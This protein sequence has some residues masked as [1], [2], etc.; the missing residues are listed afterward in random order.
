MITL[1]K[2][3]HLKSLSGI[4]YKDAFSDR[5]RANYE[6]LT[7]VMPKE[8]L[9]H[10]LLEEPEHQEQTNHIAMIVENIAVLNQNS[11]MIELINQMLN[12]I[13]MI[14]ET[15]ITYQDNVYIGCILRKMG[16]S[17]VS[18]FLQRI[19]S[20]KEEYILKNQLLKKY[21]QENESLSIYELAEHEKP[22]NQT[23]TGIIQNLEKKKENFL[24]EHIIQRLRTVEIYQTVSRWNYTQGA[25]R[26]ILFHNELALSEQQENILNIRLVQEKRKQIYPHCQMNFISSN[27]YEAELLQNIPDRKENITVENKISVTRENVF[28]CLLKAAV[29]SLAKNISLAAVFRQFYGKQQTDWY[30]IGFEICNTAKNTVNRC[31]WQYQKEQAINTDDIQ[32]FLEQQNHLYHYELSILERFAANMENRKKLLIYKKEE[33]ELESNWEQTAWNKNV[34]EQ[35]NSEQNSFYEDRE[36]KIGLENKEISFKLKE[37]LNEKNTKVIQNTEKWKEK[38]ETRKIN[39]KWKKEVW[40]KENENS[41]E[42]WYKENKKLFFDLYCEMQ[43]IEMAENYLGKYFG[44]SGKKAEE[45]GEESSDVFEE[46]LIWM[47][48]WIEEL[49]LKRKKNREQLYEDNQKQTVEY[50]FEGQFKEKNRENKW[51]NS[52]IKNDFSENNSMFSQTI[53]TTENKSRKENQKNENSKVSIEEKPKEKIAEKEQMQREKMQIEKSTKEDIKREEVK[54]KNRKEE[55][56]NKKTEKE[57]IQ[58]EKLQIEKEKIQKEKS[59]KEKLQIENFE[60]EEIQK[61]RATEEIREIFHQFITQKRAPYEQK[62][63]FNISDQPEFFFDTESG[64]AEQLSISKSQNLYENQT[65]IIE[66]QKNTDQPNSVLQKESS[67]EDKIF[68]KSRKEV[69]QVFHKLNLQT[70]QTDNKKQTASIP[71]LKHPSSFIKTQSE[72]VVNELALKSQNRY[73]G[74]EILTDI[75][76]P[77]IMNQDNT[78]IYKNIDTYNNTNIYNNTDTYNNTGT[79]NNTDTYNSVDTY[80]KSQIKKDTLEQIIE[81]GKERL[82]ENIYQQVIKPTETISAK[83]SASKHM[84]IMETEKDIQK[85]VQKEVEKYAE[86]EVIQQIFYEIET[87]NLHEIQKSTEN[88][89]NN[90][91]YLQKTKAAEIVYHQM[92]HDM[93]KPADVSQTINKDTTKTIAVTEKIL[94]QNQI[95]LSGLPAINQNQAKSDT[96]Q[97]NEAVQMIQNNIQKHINQMTEQIYQKIEKKLQNERRRRGL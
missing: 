76:Q 4:S 41:Q 78:A 44:I 27:L 79:Y 15:G 50:F 28:S 10:L 19:L 54:R 42:H 25:G 49:F 3:L 7:A 87:E 53:Q 93:S 91:N 74:S 1:K 8:E 48:E 43:R 75:V 37:L 38:K 92:G 59:D 72:S 51:S 23:D 66:N 46:R 6:F 34:T 21:K 83:E 62:E 14:K 68:E 26:N 61:E 30:E 29:F 22:T 88:L 12:R 73:Q 18:A 5:I 35:N 67:N 71:S 90:K 69:Q 24:Y 13:L 40:N 89:Y 16:I 84:S 47:S 70:Q 57:K 86:K 17:D 95:K 80:N 55:F 32:K 31:Q 85:E 56:E 81:A 33:K 82:S 2:P 65:N 52:T 45:I 60:K 94:S 58:T 20:R 63:N 77:E 9:L 39:D 11:I 97:I 36:E 64:R 96:K